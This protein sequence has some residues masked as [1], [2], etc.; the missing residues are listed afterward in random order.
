MSKLREYDQVTSTAFEF[1]KTTYG[2]SDSPAIAGHYPG[3]FSK[4]YFLE[5]R[6]LVFFCDPDHRDRFGFSF[7]PV[8]FEGRHHKRIRRYYR[9]YDYSLRRLLRILGID[10]EL[11]KDGPSRK[12]SN[13]LL[14][15]LKNLLT[16]SSLEI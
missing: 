9:L 3:S 6:R 13:L 14:A 4:T 15:R 2:Y 1:L 12:P 11:P 7:Q 8:S 10:E 16:I 5:E